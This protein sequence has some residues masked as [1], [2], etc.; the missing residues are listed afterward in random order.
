MTDPMMTCEE[1]A[2]L[3]PDH[4]ENALDAA[5]RA[6]VERHVAGCADCAAL[7]ADL[8]AIRAEAASLPLLAPSRDLWSGIEERIERGTVVPIPV[9]ESTA[10]AADVRPA[11][12]VPKSS[13]R[14]TRA[15]VLAWR[16]QAAAAAVLI[17]VS[18]GV[19]Y[20]AVK[21]D[22]GQQV[23]SIPT[24]K[25]P[26]AERAAPPVEVAEA[27][28]T[29][30][31]DLPP[32]T[33]VGDARAPRRAAPTVSRD[34]AASTG[35]AATRSPVERDIAA[36]RRI[37]AERRAVLDTAT[38]TAIEQNL[39]IIDE[40]IARSRAALEKDPAS[41]FLAGQLNTVLERKLELLRSAA[42][43]PART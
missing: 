33:R 29:E 39:R 17:A 25:G 19:T 37:L 35:R 21:P 41:Q 1:L 31:V 34:G 24:P 15:R 42:L 6:A 8:E 4:L 16:W 40:A 30:G 7:V 43:M 9:A 14:A 36:M 13:G 26:E 22:A 11:T 3:L 28:P 5:Q 23:A 12:P 27:P 18:S 38:V 2:L 32:V 10:T 20:L